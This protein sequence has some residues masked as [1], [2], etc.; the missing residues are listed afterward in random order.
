[1][2]AEFGLNQLM[3]QINTEDS[4]K[5]SELT[6]DPTPIEGE[7]GNF[8]TSYTI[9]FDPDDLPDPTAITCPPIGANTDIKVTVVGTLTNGSD[10]YQQKISRTLSVC[11]AALNQFRVRAVTSS[12]ENNA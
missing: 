5:L 1:M 12:G 11:V 6:N 4:D 9:D 3:A 10:T 7:D 2:A 8:A